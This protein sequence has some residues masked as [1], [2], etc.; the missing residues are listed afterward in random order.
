MKRFIYYTLI[1]LCMTLQTFAQTTYTYDDLNRL[2]TVKYSNGVTVSYTYDALGNRTSKKVTGGSGDEEPTS[3][4]ELV[5]LGLSVK[6]AN[7]NIDATATSGQGGYYA[8]GETKTKSKYSWATYTHCDGTAASCTNIGTSIAKKKT[9]DRAYAYNTTMCLPTVAQW[10]ELIT[11]CTW[12]EST[13]NSV[14]GYKVKGPSGKTIFL[15][16]SGCSYDGSNYGSGSYAYYWSANNVSSDVSKAQAAYVKSGTKTTVAN[17]NR[18]TGMAIRAVSVATTGE[19]PTPTG[20][21]ELVDLG[22]S[23]KWA[24]M[25]IDATATSGQGGYYAWG[26]TK[27]KSKYSW[28]T[29]THCDG[30]ASSCTNIGTSIAKKKS[31]DRAYA[32]NTTMCLPTVAQWNEL[33][34]K[35]TWT[36]STVNSVKGYKVKGP[37]GK[38]IFLPFSGCSYDGSN[39][40]SGSYAYYWSANNVSSDVSK[41]QAAYV[42]S[43]TKT[44]VANLNRRTGMAIRAV[45]VATTGEDP[46]P[47]GTIELVDLGLSVKWA[48]MN[49]DA[50][51]TSGQGGYYAWGETKTK[52]KYSWATYTHCDGTAAS[53][54]NIGTSIAKKKSYDRAYAYNTTMCLPTVAQWNELITKCTWTES[55]VNSVKGYKVKG[56][57]GKTIF[58]P[59]SGCSYDGSNYGS[60][61][62]AYY[63]SANNVS[64][65]V[66]KAQAAY[67][68][69]GTKTTVANLNRRTGMA[70]RAVS[71]ATTG[72]DPTPTGSIELVDL[73][74]SVKWANM[75]IDAT[76]TSGQGGYYAWGE[77]GTKSKYSWATYI[78]CDG[79]AASCTSIGSNIS[80]KK[81]YDR[82]YSYSNVLCIPTVTQWNELITKCTWTAATVNSVKGYNVK[83]PSGKTIFLP[84]SGCS[85]DGSN[86]GSG[87]YGYYWSAN[88]VSSDVS[89]AQAAYVKSGTKTTI[90]NLNRRTGVAI[91]AVKATTSINGSETDDINYIKEQD[92]EDDAIYTLQGIR[93]VGNPQPGIYIKNG[94]K[95]VVK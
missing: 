94:Q 55:T 82:A 47:T 15:P 64:S 39:Y 79:T 38:T 37:S 10:N 6:W 58:L 23:V 67:V 72:E 21:I 36:E 83:G 61:S 66:S 60:G 81:A 28:A 27:T 87:S 16:F 95:I 31:Y 5:D 53:C 41:A 80:K 90:A 26:E 22:L 75:N 92:T 32:Y 62:Y 35:C 17:L 63:W 3:T 13:V 40:G 50:T 1:F 88:N 52:S 49:I 34:T 70:I 59:F 25:N 93:V 48:N 68:K 76:A 51:A 45:S 14:K 9:Y 56:P 44:T 33:I 86:Y 65:D 73:G 57:S 2:K 12:T 7:M 89:K 78:Y 19:D 20:T 8:W 74:L 84:F 4:I 43:G 69:S 11:K 42:K 85:Y 71:V 77:L 24:N 29:Y 30:T 91:R 46:T 54:T 18:R